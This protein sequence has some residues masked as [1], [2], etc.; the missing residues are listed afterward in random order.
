[1]SLELAGF[2]RHLHSIARVSFGLLLIVLAIGLVTL[3]YTVGMSLLKPDAMF[4]SR[5]WNIGFPELM[6]LPSLL[7][8]CI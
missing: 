3:V 8:N 2:A 5:L 4:T 6:G 7:I 1:M